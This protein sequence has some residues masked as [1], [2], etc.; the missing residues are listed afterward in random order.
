MCRGLD[1]LKFDQTPLIYSVSYN[2]LGGLGTLFGGPK[3]TKASPW[4]RDWD[5]RSVSK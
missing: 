2:N 4:R 5:K 1:I 3:P